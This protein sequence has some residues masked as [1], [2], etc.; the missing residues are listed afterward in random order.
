MYYHAFIETPKTTQREN[1]EKKYVKD[2]DWRGSMKE[3][4]FSDET[5]QY[6]DCGVGY[7]N[8]HVMKCHKNTPKK[9]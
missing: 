2:N 9:V 6:P 1:R 8:L 5:V 4:H 3:F 7:T